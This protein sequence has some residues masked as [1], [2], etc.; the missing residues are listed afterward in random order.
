M[1]LWEGWASIKA[2]G[3]W[4]LYHLEHEKCG[5]VSSTAYG[6]TDEDNGQVRRV[7]AGHEKICPEPGHDP[8]D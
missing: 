4:S 2:S 8:G 1:K 3:W 7:M 5:W 6:S